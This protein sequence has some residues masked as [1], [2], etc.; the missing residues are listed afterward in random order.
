MG[1][2]RPVGRVF[3]GD[4]FVSV[5]ALLDISFHHVVAAVGVSG[6]VDSVWSDGPPPIVD[7][8]RFIRIYFDHD[9]QVVWYGYDLIGK[10][11]TVFDF[12]RCV[13]HGG[14]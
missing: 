1:V 11:C 12:R 14:V 4:D 9:R 13:N 7:Q 6:C 3:V 10:G 8:W 2:G 5:F